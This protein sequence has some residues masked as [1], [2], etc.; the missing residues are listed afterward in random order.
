MGVHD[1]ICHFHHND[2]NLI[3]IEILDD[4]EDDL[5]ENSDDDDGGDGC[6]SSSAIV[7]IVPDNVEIN[8]MKYG[9]FAK[10]PKLELTYS[11][12]NWDFDELTGYDK[13]LRDDESVPDSKDASVW[14]HKK[15]P[16]KFLVNFEPNTYKVFVTGEISPDSVSLK[17]Y[18]RILRDRELKYK[19]RN[20]FDLYRLICNPENFQPLEKIDDLD[21]LFE[22]GFNNIVSII[23]Q[24]AIPLEFVKNPYIPEYSLLI[25]LREFNIIQRDDRPEFAIKMINSEKSRHKSRPPLPPGDRTTGRA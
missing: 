7:V 5:D 10:Y 17:S 9:D 25:W 18:R 11:W 21:Y 22:K 1:Y 13:F 3:G 2:Q 20:K 6:G 23:G 19:G 8:K 15:Y 16:G 12:D 24:Y 14:T 4:P